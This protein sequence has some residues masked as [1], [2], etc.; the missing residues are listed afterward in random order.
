MVEVE[1]GFACVVAVA[2]ATRMQRMESM[3]LNPVTG[4]GQSVSETLL[5][6]L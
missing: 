2:W 6:Q 4:V 5:S 1:S 3:M